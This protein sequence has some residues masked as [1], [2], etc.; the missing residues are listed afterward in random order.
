[1][2]DQVWF[3]PDRADIEREVAAHYEDHVR[4]LVRLD[5]PVEFA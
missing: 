5:Y 3:K 4:D 1:M 2:M